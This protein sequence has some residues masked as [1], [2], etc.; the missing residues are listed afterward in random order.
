MAE[1]VIYNGQTGSY[2]ECSDPEVLSVGKEY[3]VIWK[4]DR[5]WQTDYVLKG[6]KGRFNSCWFEPVKK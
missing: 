3:E 4:F 2:Y 1:I 5:G 6:I